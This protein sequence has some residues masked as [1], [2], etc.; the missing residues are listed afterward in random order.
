MMHLF[1]QVG[2]S[3]AV[4]ICRRFMFQILSPISCM[5]KKHWRFDEHGTG[6]V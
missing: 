3:D 6:L 2:F 5:H 1:G 4:W